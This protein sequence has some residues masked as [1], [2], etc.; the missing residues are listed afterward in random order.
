M[1]FKAMIAV[2]GMPVDQRFV[3]PGLSD[4]FRDQVFAGG[5]VSQGRMYDRILFGKRTPLPCDGM[6][7][8]FPRRYRLANPLK[9][10]GKGR[11][12]GYRYRDGCRRIPQFIVDFVRNAA[13]CGQLHSWHCCRQDWHRT[14]RRLA[15]AGWRPCTA[16]S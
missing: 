16:F 5:F 6:R 8:V 7:E 12:I 15:H 3:D 14:I 2:D 4:F 10:A 11:S 9:D 13:V 1:A